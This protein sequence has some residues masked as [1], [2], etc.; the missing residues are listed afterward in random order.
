MKKLLLLISLSLFF[1]YSCISQEYHF[2]EISSEVKG[3]S[4]G[5]VKQSGIIVIGE[6][7]VDIKFTKKN[8]PIPSQSYTI[9]NLIKNSKFTQYDSSI[10]DVNPSHLIRIILYDKINNEG[11]DESY[12]IIDT[13]DVFTN[14]VTKMTYYIK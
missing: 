13:K 6:K 12:M 3:A 10:G 14:E 11:V 2:N 5:K 7:L 1:K 4:H 8:T 9:N